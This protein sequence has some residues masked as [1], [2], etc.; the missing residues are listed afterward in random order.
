[1]AQV[2]VFAPCAACRKVFA[3]SP[4]RVPSVVIDGMRQPICADC[5]ALA[6]PQR[7]ANGLEP[8]HVLP[9]AYEPD[10]E[11]EVPWSDD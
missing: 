1:M 6:N 4:T 7:I 10:D 11:S 2:Y 5:V 9:G 8:I 3:C